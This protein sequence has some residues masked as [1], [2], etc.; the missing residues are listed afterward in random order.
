MAVAGIGVDGL[1]NAAAAQTAYQTLNFGTTGT[2]LTGI[3]G[4][5]IVGNYTIGTE[6]GG[7]YYNMATQAWSPMPVSTADGVNYPGAISS[8]PYGPSFGNP[9]GILRTVGSYQTTASAPYDL[10]YLYDGAAAPGQSITPLAFP[11]SSTLYTIAHSNFGDQVVGDYDTDLAQ[12]KAFIYTISTGTYTPLVISNASTTAYGVYGDKIAG[13]YAQVLEGGGL[14]PEH[15]YIYDQTTGTYV[16]HDHPDAVATH[17]EGITGGGRAGEYNLVTNWISA[18]GAVHPAVLHVAADGTTTWYEIDIPGDVVSANSAYGDNVIGVYIAN[19][20][21]NGYVATLPGIYNPIRNDAPLNVAGNGAIGI[22]TNPGG[23]DVINTSSIAITGSGA[24]G[25]AAETY[26]VISNKGTITVTGTDSTGVRMNGRYGTLLNSG[27]LTA[28]AGATTLSSGPDALGTA[29]VNTGIIDGQVDIASGMQ[30][31]FE[32]SGWLGVSGAGAGTV[33]A[34]SGTF[35]QTAG[36][37]LALRLDGASNDRV[38]TDTARLAGTLA[39]SFQSTS[40]AKSYTLLTATQDVTGSFDTFA[41]SGLPAMFATRLNYGANAVTL[42][43]ASNL[44]GQAN[45][46]PNQQAVGRAIDRVVNNS[47]GPL[48]LALPAGLSPL[49]ALDAAQL[50][51]ALGALSG[52]SYASARSV[53]IGDGLYSR[54]AILGR[55]RQGAYQGQ[56][57]PT[58]ALGYGGPALAYG[59]AFKSAATP[60]FPTKSPFPTKAPVAEPAPFAGTVWA[61][62]FGGWSDYEGGSTTADVD[63]TIGGFMVG[64]DVPVSDWLV[65]LAAGYSRSSSNSSALL[66]SSDVDSGLLAL[67]AGTRAGAWNLRLGATYAF[68]SID[69]SRTIAFPGYA[70]QASAAYDGSTA[71]VFGEVGYGFAVQGLA[72]EPFAGLAYVHL[73]TDGFRESGALNGVNG[74]SGSLDVGYSSLGLRI[75]TTLEL[76]GGMVLRPHA[77]LAWQYAF[78]DTTPEARLELQ[79]LPGATFSVA[80]VPLAQN[81]ALLELGTE[82]AVNERT[83]I[84]VA[85][86]GQYADSV[87]VNAIQAR[88]SWRF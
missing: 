80:G 74:A 61:Q 14:G 22:A 71:Q 46:T 84:G 54:Q 63:A 49:Y 59:A 72:I 18:D 82:L 83:S 24:T 47:S 1:A 58:G 32:N 43:V 57:D 75:A 73:D 79:N 6:T 40:I 81:T 20:T 56:P 68:N 50:P 41:T 65:G 85:Y 66:A 42:G 25:I 15:G 17:F 53:M 12:G 39:T 16:T 86:V 33:H 4:D 45:S 11:G 34:I 30:G 9:G 55:L 5:N 21:V 8:S 3:R 28:S 51:V 13:G 77:S 23:D 87:T 29:V 69:A 48:L 7:L 27:S 64:A 70:Q 88:L 31:R 62:G 26:G 76:P 67:Y 35:A 52:E 78:G 36:G 44:G 10:S 2:F 37:T 60:P 38:Q 19:G